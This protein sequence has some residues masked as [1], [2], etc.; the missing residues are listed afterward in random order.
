MKLRFPVLAVCLLSVAVSS[1]AEP[2][3][4][5]FSTKMP[6]SEVAAPPTLF[7]SF[8]STRDTATLEKVVF[9]AVAPTPLLALTFI[10]QPPI[11]SPTPEPSSLVLLATGALGLAEAQRRRRKNRA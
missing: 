9:A 8:A 6:A 3:S 11:S 2:I 7:E 4:Y 10:S 5:E 1:Y